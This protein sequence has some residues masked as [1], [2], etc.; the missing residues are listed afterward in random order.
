[1][2]PIFS[3]LITDEDLVLLERYDE[4]LTK[5]VTELPSHSSGTGSD[6]LRYKSTLAGLGYGGI[7]VPS[8][9]GGS[10]RSSLVQML[11]QFV[12]GYHDVDF[13]DIAHIAHGRMILTNGSSEQQRRWLPRI[14]NGDLIGIASTEK[15]GGTTLDSITTRAIKIGDGSWSLSGEKFWISRLSESCAFVVF[16]KTE[17]HTQVSAAIIDAQSQGITR[18][19]FDSIGL[20]GWSWG[21]LQFENVRFNETDFLA[22]ENDGLSVFRKHFL[23]Y[24]PMIAATALGGAAAV[25][26]NVVSQIQQKIGSRTIQDCRDSTLETL[27]RSYIAIHSS[28][29]SA[30]MAQK[31]VS[32]DAPLASTWSRAVKAHSVDTAYRAVS[33][34]TILA[35][36]SSY[37][38][39]DRL[40][41]VQRDLQGLLFADG[42]HDALYRAAGRSLLKHVHSNVSTL[43]P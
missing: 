11:V 12:S 41:K 28:L 5:V 24:R 38:A 18:E 23:Y 30:M 2:R 13:R 26:D 14:L 33:D 22:Q 7:D 27:A 15:H 35:G 42:I 8:A 25:F 34:L 6:L 31:L 37:Q 10:G 1:M 4:D 17:N 32:V 40:S 29:L 36:A 20:H 19:K 43:S 9:L 3:D 39:H 21:R 16:F